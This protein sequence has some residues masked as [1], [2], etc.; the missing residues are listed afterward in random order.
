MYF[1]LDSIACLLVLCMHI[2]RMLMTT[3][4]DT[5]DALKLLDSTPCSSNWNLLDANDW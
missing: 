5:D 3:E 4:L 1:G 2:S